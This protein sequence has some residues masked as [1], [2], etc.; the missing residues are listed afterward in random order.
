MRCPNCQ[1]EI[2]EGLAVCTGC[3]A[4]L[5]EYTQ[6][7]RPAAET[8]EYTQ[9]VRP[10]V[11]EAPVPEEIPAPEET[12]VPEEIPVPEETAVPQETPLVLN[13]DGQEPVPEPV[14]KPKKKKVVGIIAIVTALA[15]L[16]TGVL[17][18]FVFDWGLYIRDFFERQKDPVE[19]KDIVEERALAEGSVTELNLLK[20]WFLEAYDG[21]AELGQKGGQDIHAKVT[22]DENLRSLLKLA[23]NGDAQLSELVN[24]LEQVDITFSQDFQPEI[25]QVKLT[26]S[27]NEVDILHLD[28][29]MDRKTDKIYA[30]I[31]E[32]NP[33]YLLLD[34]TDYESPLCELSAYLI[35]VM[36]MLDQGM[37]LYSQL[38]AR[39]DVEKALDSCILDVIH[40]IKDVKKS[41]T[42]LEASGIEQDVTVLTYRIDQLTMQQ[43]GLTLLD[44]V[45]E[46]PALKTVIEA[47]CSATGQS[48]DLEAARK[49][50]EEVEA[51]DD[52]V[53]RI[54]TYVNQKGQ[55]VGRNF[56]DVGTGEEMEYAL[57]NKGKDIGIRMEMYSG[58]TEST[59]EGKAAVENDKLQGSVQA[60]SNEE[61]L[62]DLSFSDLDIKTFRGDL[63]VKLGEDMKDEARELMEIPMNAVDLGE[64]RLDLKL[65]EN[66]L[67]VTLGAGSMNALFVN[68]TVTRREAKELS[69][70]EKTANGLTVGWAS[71]LD[72][73]TIP[74]NLKEANLE[75]LAEMATDLMLELSSSLIRSYLGY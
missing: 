56:R 3:G 22:M 57:V 63:T 39:A 5:T 59:L 26:V 44:N 45:E 4:N 41:D 30:A 62:L 20:S 53:L 19:Y 75:V 49:S 11:E 74:D 60:Y 38:P 24:N 73:K 9:V 65:Q 32:L 55:I 40:C 7:V 6:V 25:H 14:K 21:M 61:H 68:G 31:P 43:M 36:N 29:V 64:V 70:P 69:L 67:D 34:N 2:P 72:L 16:I 1:Q 48:L 18:F 42:T 58:E 12:P 17:G 51:T 54:E 66:A 52:V 35:A 28:M 8:A 50:L 10:A 23:V 47:Y 33:S 71:T 37:E 46:H 13:M 27:A 15:L